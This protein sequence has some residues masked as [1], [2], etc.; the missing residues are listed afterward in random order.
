MISKKTEFAKKLIGSKYDTTVS[1][2][3]IES[4]LNGSHKLTENQYKKQKCGDRIIPENETVIPSVCFSCHSTCEVLIYK[5]KNTGEI[6][7]IEGDPDSPQTR[8]MLCPKGLA[9]KQ[10]VYNPKR[11]LKPL[12]RVGKRGEGKWQEISWDEA[13]D[14][15]AEKLKEYKEKYGPQGLAILEGTRR[16]WS[17][18]YT[19]FANVLQAPNHGAAGWAQCLWPR[20]I[21]CNLTFGGGAQYGEAFDFPNTHCILAWGVNPVTCWGVRAADIML[22]KQRGAALIVVDP[23]FSE[24]AAKA[25]IWLQVRPDTDMALALSFINVIIEEG[26]TDDDFIEKWTYGYEELKNHVKSYTP[27]WAS[28]I[29]GVDADLIRKA[30]RV[31]AKAEAACVIRGLA[32]DQQHDSVQVC[33]ATSIL[34]SITGNIGKKGG[35]VVVSSRGDISQNTHE[36]I[37]A[38][39]IPEEIRKLRIGYN[40]F[41]LLTQ[42]LS[43]VPVAHMPSLWETIIS[44]KPYPIKCATIFGS[45]AIVSYTNSNKVIEA[46]SRLEF[47]AVCDIFMTPTAEMA[48]IV[49][50][51][52]T[53][54]ER[55]N[56][57]SSFQSS[58]TYTLIQQKAVTI[59]EAKN[60]VDIIIELAKRL[61]LEEHFWENSEK[62]YD[63]LL[64]PTGYTFKEAAA[65]RRLYKPLTYESYKEKGFKTPTGKIELYSNL[66]KAKGC[67]PLP[68]YTPSFQSFDSTPE[69]AEEYPLIITTGRHES[70]FRISENRLQPYLLELV[71]KPYLYINPKTARRLGIENGRKV[72]V[73]STAG[74]AYAYAYYTEG[75]REDVVQATSGWW[76]E[77][78]INKTVPWGKYAEGIGTVCARGYLCRVTPAENLGD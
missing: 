34:A 36:F 63:Y 78:N 21:D 32:L 13:L 1:Q 6:L 8:G 16:G 26:L 75:L 41:P 35:N 10:L 5:D 46:L 42:E 47:I 7:R 30:A 67:D 59:D 40:E 48:D 64:S 23:Y 18:V 62:F 31:Y 56:V 54:L 65:K 2:N 69:L 58:N 15:V 12:K 60:D 25:D 45:N 3:I 27:E 77:Y 38:D 66:A 73:E 74:Y 50:P 71:P 61:G 68:R 9:A 49:L 55:N 19:R 17:R 70:A 14:T 53:W 37:K 57:I 52:S 51:A 4:I 44:G 76:G 39:F 33:R 72:K 28:K 43:P 29:T 24:T 22:A 20:L 11:L